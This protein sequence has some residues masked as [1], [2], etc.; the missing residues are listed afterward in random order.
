MSYWNVLVELLNSASSQISC[1]AATLKVG[2][3]PS[4]LVVLFPVNHGLTAA[5]SNCRPFGPLRLNEFT[6]LARAPSAD[7]SCGRAVDD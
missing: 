2:A 4:D 3:G 1:N 5:A 7:S 6:A